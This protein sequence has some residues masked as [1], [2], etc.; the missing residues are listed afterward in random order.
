LSPDCHK[1]QIYSNGGGNILANGRC[2][3]VKKVLFQLCRWAGAVVVL[4]AWAGSALCV[5]ANP[6]GGTVTQGSATFSGSG[7]QF[8]INQT[9]PGAF[10]NWQSF[11]IG[12]GETVNFNQPS[13]SSVTW[14]Q[15]NDSNPSQ[16]L[17]SLNANGYVVLQNSAGFYVGGQAAISAH[18]LI[19]T[20]ASARA[21][22]L[23]SG[24]PWSFDAP[25][26]AAKI[27]NYGRINIAGGGPAFLIASD[28]EN[29]GAIS[30][31]DGKIGLYAGQTVLLSTSPDGRGLSAQITLPQGS[32][33][34]KGELI[35]D[36]G[37]IAAQARVVNQGGLIQANSAQNVN[38]TIELVGGN[39]VNLGASSV[40]SA[41]GDTQ[42]ASPGGSVT[43]Q[44]GNSFSDQAGSVISIAGG[45]QGGNGGQAE[46]SAPRMGGINTH[47][48]GEA[49]DGF[50]GGFLTIDPL[51]IWLASANTDPA[52]PAD[53][54]VVNVNSFSG[55]SQINLQAD[56]NITLNTVWT[57][58]D[59]TAPANLSL[60]AGNDI[61]LNLYSG[62]SAG[63]NWNVNLTAG[64]G[65]VPT[66]G[67]P[68]PS[69]GSDGI[70]L[71]GGSPLILNGSSSYIKTQNGNINLWAANEVQVGWSGAA[72]LPGQVNTGS[73]GITTANGGSINATTV[74]GDVN[75]GSDPAG[76]VYYAT[77]PYDRVDPQL[78]GISTAAGG[79]VTIAVGGNVI[80]YLP[81]GNTST[82][83]EDGGVGAFGPGAVGNVTVTAEGNVYGHFVVAD[84]NGVVTSLNGNIGAANGNPF[85]L[86]LIS[87][88]WSVNAPNGKIYL[89]E[90]RNPNGDFNNKSSKF[91]GSP[92]QFLFNYDP[93]GYVDLSADGV[94]LTG[95]NVPRPYG[96]I[97]VLYPPI[98]DITAGGGGVTL[99]GNVTLFPSPDQNIDITTV[100][101]GNFTA[102]QNSTGVPYYL[103]M[104][105]SAQ[106][107]WTGANAFS[108][109]DHGTLQNEPT[110]TI[111]A[112]FKISGS[113][114]NLNLITTK[115]TDITVGGDMINCGYSG[116]NLQADDH[117]VITVAGQILN[118]S[119]YSFVYLNQA[120]PNI[121]TADLPVGR[122]NAWDDIFTLAVNPALIANLQ[123]PP[124]IPASQWLNY[125]LQNYGLFQ[126]QTINGQLVGVNPGFVYDPATGQFGFA[127]P[128]TPTTLSALTQP[129]T[130]LH[131]V[132]GQP[133][134]DASPGDNSPGRT[135]G[136]LE[137]DTIS[138]A[139]PSAVQA[140]FADS[141]GRPSPANL[142]L[143]D[144]VGGPGYFDIT[145]GSISLGN[146]Y[147]ILSCGVFDAQ[148]GFDRY[149]NLASI[150]PEGAT[151]N[152]TTTGDLNML[153]STI[154]ALGGGNVNVISTGGAMDLGSG[155]LFAST[156]S[157]SA[158][159]HLAYGI[160]TTGG[161]N[162][163]V[164]ALGDVDINGSRIAAYNGGNISVESLLGNVNVG[165]GTADLNTVYVAYVDPATGQ[166]AYY[167]ED[168]F[169][170][171][172]VAST[173]V[174]PLAGL[175]YPPDAA[176]LPGNITVATPQG[177]IVAGTGGILQVALDGSITAGPTVTLTAGT[178]PSGKPGTPDYSPG[179]AGNID[180]GDSGVIGGT[181]NLAAN[182][183]ITGQVVSRQNSTVNAAQNF[184]GTLLSGGSANVKGGGTVSGT[185][186]GVSG[187]SV[188]G[189]GGVTASVLGQ[190][191]SVNGGASQSTLGSSATATASTQSAVGQASQAATQQ[192]ANDTKGN[193][194]DEKNKRKKK[195]VRTVGRVTV[196]LSTTVTPQ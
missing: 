84:G 76:Y 80:S 34:N 82:A 59:Q 173:L 140:L 40:I 10:I 85:A 47:I 166:S 29:N 134:I 182:G 93:Q 41:R 164:N 99:E 135:Y 103:L 26:P 170:S 75:T 195:L 22:V 73:G 123:I 112:V 21:P 116:Q 50:S 122:G 16:I 37:A 156:S 148:G 147:G 28:I 155:D 174:P 20:T 185:I 23:S 69:S 14:N 117:T 77:T 58:A 141:Q 87:G 52:A 111:P 171:G 175:A 74:Y 190:N 70:Y 172:I 62:I 145:A 38:G 91:G 138:W 149:G 150:T 115:V 86:S 3:T 110:E 125:V 78:G 30:A 18:G 79:D 152:V 65:F 194:D 43:I 113:M 186:I 153:T 127:G 56:N 71:Y 177:D 120:I 67:Q 2:F 98:L 35:A 95:L 9:T 142:Q 176:K 4:L 193:G 25:P 53:Y 119:A 12:A 136:Q 15:I 154:G 129:I 179:H 143:G 107:R 39:S 128:M 131:L 42:G 169:G 160:Y 81:S 196:I 48:N 137:T 108:A 46:I 109:N 167:Q 24:G 17:G 184:S 144:R 64:T 168:V 157:S 180:L 102:V 55:L 104:S 121:P 192:V 27:V 165:N 162:V 60:T 124:N 68:K 126:V 72:N 97:P 8:N 92:G 94:Y 105:D 96:A 139:A 189:G 49:A 101:G 106:T 31:P 51:N 66:T 100:D 163:N 158:A 61:T 19:M 151:V 146:S 132:N 83:A 33:D 54:S 133:V 63:Q 6:T 45:A 5:C 130:I 114:E 88:G 13:A 32:V 118:T 178:A 161:G 183:N 191:V 89:Q 181:V 188:S 44:G 36:G 11:N 187:A 57:L 90:V 1:K 159:N 7:T